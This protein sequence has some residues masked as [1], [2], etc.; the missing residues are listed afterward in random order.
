MLTAKES[1]IETWSPKTFSCQKKELWKFVILAQRRSSMKR[2]RIL[3]TSWAD[4]TELPNSFLESL[5][6][7][8][9]S[10]FGVRHFSLITFSHWL[11]L[12]RAYQL[13]ATFPRED[14]R[15]SIVGTDCDSGKP[16]WERSERNVNEHARRDHKS[17]RRDWE[18]QAEIDERLVS[19]Q[20]LWCKPLKFLVFRKT[21]LIWPLTA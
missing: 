5:H 10:I 7:D 4:F 12:W 14:R 19:S 17:H 16:D 3:P 6:M 20:R 15:I 8:Q 1:S 21:S 18:I 11:H 2:E 13:E 9:K